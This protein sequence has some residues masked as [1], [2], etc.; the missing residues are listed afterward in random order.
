MA[1]APEGTPRPKT[2]YLIFKD[3]GSFASAEE[4]PGLI[5]QYQGQIEAYSNE[6]AR[7][8]FVGDRLGGFAA[9]AATAWQP[10]ELKETKTVAW[11]PMELP[12]SGEEDDPV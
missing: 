8:A 10:H 6:A 11:V 7:K 9:V 1:E 2:T 3:I 12:G 5:W 4:E